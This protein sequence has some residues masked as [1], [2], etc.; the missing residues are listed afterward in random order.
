MCVRALY[1]RRNSLSRIAVWAKGTL[2]CSIAGAF[3]LIAAI[4][5]ISGWLLVCA[6]WVC[7]ALCSFISGAAQISLG[8]AFE[9]LRQSTKVLASALL[10][11]LFYGGRTVATCAQLPF[12]GGAKLTRAVLAAGVKIGNL[13]GAICG[14][15]LEVA[16]GALVG[17][18]LLNLKG[19]QGLLFL[20]EI[21]DVGARACAAVLFGAFMG[22]TLGLSRATWA[23]ESET[24]V[25]P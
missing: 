12:R 15:L 7:R 20:P 18:I 14:M 23:R 8:V 11:A 19:V 25:D 21:D 22:I 9:S 24:A 16:S 2:I 3:R 10:A 13:S 17:A 4:L 6:L 5:V 1:L